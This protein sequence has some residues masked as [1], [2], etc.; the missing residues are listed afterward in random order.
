MFNTLKNLLTSNEFFRAVTL[1]L[2]AAGVATSPENIEAIVSGVFAALGLIQ[3]VRAAI[4][5]PKKAA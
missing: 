5:A 3:A 2:G 4:K 1:G